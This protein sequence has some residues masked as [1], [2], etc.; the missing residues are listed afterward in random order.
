MDDAAVRSRR[1]AANSLAQL[2]YRMSWCLRA[3]AATND[4]LQL[5]AEFIIGNTEQLEAEDREEAL[6]QAHRA[7]QETHAEEDKW[8]KSVAEQLGFVPAPPPRPAPAS[9]PPSVS[10]S[11]SPAAAGKAGREW[12]WA[13]TV[14]PMY[15]RGRA[16]A[17]LRESAE[18]RAHLDAVLRLVGSATRRHDEAVV[19]ATNAVSARRGA[20]PLTLAPTDVFPDDDAATGGVPGLD[21]VAC[22]LRYLMLRNAN[23]RLSHVL[24][25]LDLSQDDSPGL[26]KTLRRLR[27][28]VFTAVKRAEL[29]SVL[30]ESHSGDGF[31]MQ[32]FKLPTVVLDRTSRNVFSQLFFQ[33]HR[34]VPA[35]ALRNSER[36]FYCI[37]AGEHSDDFGG[38]YR[39]ALDQ[40]CQE[41]MRDGGVLCRTKRGWIPHPRAASA[42]AIEMLEFVGK[43]CGVAIRTKTPLPLDMPSMVWKR[44][45]HEPIE[46]GDVETVDPD[47]AAQMRGLRAIASAEEWDEA[48]I[49]AR[50]AV[51][52]CD[53]RVV[54]L[55]PGG[56]SVR[57]EFAT[58]GKYLELAFRA[59]AEES[60]AQCAALAR[61]VATQVPRHLLKLFSSTELEAMVCG[62]ATVDVALLRQCTI[63]GD[64]VDETAPVVKHF[65]A[66]MDKFGEED[67]RRYL[68]FVWGRTRLPLSLG[69]WDRKHK[70]N[71]LTAVDAA[72]ADAYLPVGHTCF[73]SV[74]LPPYSSEEAC[75]RKLTY[76]VTH[77]LTIDADE[78]TNARMAAEQSVGD[79]VGA[80][81]RDVDLGF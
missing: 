7:Q 27:R 47:L 26:D 41:L 45:T 4:D 49:D 54:D 64:G 8:M 65:W 56:R 34:R 9:T 31:S 69:E 36:A 30:R 23:R 20:D 12:G 17:L 33:L 39:D 5:A 80:D 77:C 3:L 10:S 16:V 74:D 53:G 61:G 40:A 35:A 63:Y 75:R 37:L 28:L 29:E 68:R 55:V 38:P 15:T 50:F 67:R 59:K 48:L 18:T 2:G 72:D 22:R 32:R 78:T 71:L 1:A 6:L 42:L 73:F 76:A 57:V 58:R 46:L 62:P 79:A 52:G 14:T 13:M 70:I 21:P 60:A 44:L 24:P 51:A 19:E 43:L 25:L 81:Q 66:V 11:T